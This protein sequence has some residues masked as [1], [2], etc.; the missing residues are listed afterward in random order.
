MMDVHIS[1]NDPVAFLIGLAWVLGSAVG[2]YYL[3]RLLVYFNPPRHGEDRMGLAV[4]FF[5]FLFLAAIAFVVSFAL[6][7]Y[8][9]AGIAA[10]LGLGLLGFAFGLGSRA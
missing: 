7:F 8:A 2:G 5:F 6:L 4:G 1:F 10:L 9:Y 3:A